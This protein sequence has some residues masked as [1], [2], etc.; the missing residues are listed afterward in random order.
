MS[1][2]ETRNSNDFS[3]L[4]EKIP[5]TM[6]PAFEAVVKYKKQIVMGIAAI[7]V[8]AAVFGLVRW[9]RANAESEAQTALG[10]ILMNQQGAD[11]VSKLEA[12]LEDAPSSVEPA[13]LLEL[14]E[15]CMQT[16]NYGKAAEYYE[17]LAQ[18]SDD[19]VSIVAGMGRAKALI[20]AGK[21]E[22]SYT[23]LKELSEDAPESF[24]AT[25]YRQMALSAEA[26]GKTDAALKAWEALL[27]TPTADKEFVQYKLQQLKK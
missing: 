6:H 26:A 12:L 23:L 5:E 16:E 17:R 25:I 24:A 1:E 9:Q 18:N 13:I 22:E 11:R 10:E 3:N 27:E 15:A 4:E 7:F 14:S 19:T 20:L 21:A 2:N 8:I